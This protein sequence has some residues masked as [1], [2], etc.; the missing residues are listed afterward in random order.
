MS[1][2][3]C[4]FFLGLILVTGA[5][6]ENHGY[7]YLRPGTVVMGGYYGMP[8]LKYPENNFP[9][10]E[11]SNYIPTSNERPFGHEKESVTEGLV[12]VSDEEK[13][14]SEHS[15]PSTNTDKVLKSK[16]TVATKKVIPK[17]SDEDE[18][19]NTNFP[20]GSRGSSVFNAFFP[21][22]M[23]GHSGVGRKSEGDGGL[24]GGATA[25]ANSF[26]TG[27]GGVASS[28]AT[29]FGNVYFKSDM[30]NTNE[31]TRENK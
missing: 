21:I 16:E 17:K 29:S 27:R 13:V 28:H 18:L 7:R 31:R 30:E 6:F 25:I 15:T 4:T 8:P 9:P 26:S 19:S 22:M 2:L 24:D 11:N 5:Q 3:V 1:T 14:I 12:I 20:F 23:G 10:Q